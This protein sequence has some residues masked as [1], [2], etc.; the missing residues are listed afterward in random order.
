MRKVNHKVLCVL[1]VVLLNLVLPDWE[2]YRKKLVFIAI[3]YGVY[4]C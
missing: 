4:N 3:L 2:V 1:R